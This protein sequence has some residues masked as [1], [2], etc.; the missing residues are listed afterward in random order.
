MGWGWERK[1]WRNGVG[2]G[3]IG[4]GDGR[5]RCGGMRWGWEWKVWRKGVGLGGGLGWVEKGDKGEWDRTGRGRRWEV[6]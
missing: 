4:D 5:G 2:L 6:V 3:V 1:V